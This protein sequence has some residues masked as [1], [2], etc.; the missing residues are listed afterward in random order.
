M[1]GAEGGGHFVQVGIATSND[2]S[3]DR[4]DVSFLSLPNVV[5]LAAESILTLVANSKEPAG[6]L[7]T[8]F[9]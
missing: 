3:A 1:A 7:E 4:P 6:A 5:T 8:G 2:E 9:G